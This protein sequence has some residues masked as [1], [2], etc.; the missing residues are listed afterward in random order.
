MAVVQ[1]SAIVNQLRGKLGGSVFN[2]SK[3][4]FTLQKKQQQPKGSR[5]FQSEVRN[6]FAKFQ[7]T[8]KTITASQRT[9]WGV[10][11]SNNPTRDRFGNQTILSGYNQYVKANM[12]AE[13]CNAVAPATPYTSPAPP[14]VVHSMSLGQVVFSISGTGVPQINA[15]PSVDWD[16]TSSDYGYIFDISLPVSMG[17]TAYHGRFT[18][19]SG[20]L[21]TTH[22]PA[23]FQTSLGSSYPLPQSGQLMFLRSRIVHI[24]SGAVVYEE[25]SRLFFTV[26]S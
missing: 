15:N 18:N 12:L 9:Q 13:Y 17:V 1:Y 8:W 21:T 25:I 5:G 2:K 24:A 16:I 10:T 11:A 4:A 20:G 6:F 19:V 23:P 26:S 3:N 14:F 7:R 22:S